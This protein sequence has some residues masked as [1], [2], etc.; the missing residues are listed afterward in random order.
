MSSKIGHPLPIVLSDGGGAEVSGLFTD[1]RL[2]FLLSPPHEIKFHIS[3]TLAQFS[4]QKSDQTMWINSLLPGNWR[5]LMRSGVDRCSYAW[6][7]SP[8]GRPG[9][10]NGGGEFDGQCLEHVACKINLFLYRNKYDLVVC[11]PQYSSETNNTHL[12]D[13]G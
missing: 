11:D 12:Q 13:E 6:P 9:A 10:C 7:G 3:L 2:L 4:T 8:G 5:L 1:L